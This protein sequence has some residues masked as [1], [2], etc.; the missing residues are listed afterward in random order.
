MK[1]AGDE[2]VARALGAGGG[3]ERGLY[4]Q[5]AALVEEVAHVLDDL[6]AKDDVVAHPL[7]PEV[8]VAVLQAQDLLHVPL[9]V[10][11]ER[12]RLRSG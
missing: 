8:E 2:V 3:Q 7:A 11:L 12:R 4:L 5:E 10:D 9:A 6:V 1:A